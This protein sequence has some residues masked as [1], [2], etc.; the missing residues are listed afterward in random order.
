MS[1]TEVASLP[2][3]DAETLAPMIPAGRTALIVVDIQTDFA[4]PAGLLGRHGV[5]MSVAEPAIDNIETL[6]AAAR[7]AGAEVAF[8]R[9][10][11]RPETDSNALKAL[12][13]RRGMPGGQG[14]CRTDDGGADYY[15]VKPQAGD[16]EI[17]KLMFD[18]FHG[19]DL[20]AQLRARG[21]ETLVIAGISTDCC[22]DSTA[23]AAFHRDYH[24]FVVSDACA[25]FG[26]DLHYG[27]LNVLQKNVAF[28]V[29]T[30]A[31]VAAWGK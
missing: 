1:D 12:Y 24:V 9:V 2:H 20:D 17:E 4:S 25:A 3:L 19:T 6:I 27:T 15:R 13:A 8:M 10:V 5:D 23:R 26:D 28:L 18:S 31:V 11:T 22:V 7:K 14:I 30:N 29:T 21:I 16:I